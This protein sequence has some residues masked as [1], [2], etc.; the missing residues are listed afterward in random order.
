MRQARQMPPERV[1]R[2]R[3]RAP[4]ND[5]YD[6]ACELVLAAHGLRTAAGR[7][8]ASRATA[9]TL[10]CVE[11][12]LSTLAEAIGELAT[13]IVVEN[14][15]HAPPGPAAEKFADLNDSLIR[16]AHSCGLARAVVGSSSAVPDM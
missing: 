10:G 13:G 1:A 7:D 11:E 3:E 8:Q 12:V 9:P 2:T 6:C 15:G 4:E 5:L 14:E 16:A